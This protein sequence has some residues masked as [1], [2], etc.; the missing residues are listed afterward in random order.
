MANVTTHKRI[1]Y[2]NLH[3][4]DNT[5]KIIDQDEAKQLYFALYEW[6]S[7]ETGSKDLISQVL[8]S[9]KCN[10]KNG[11]LQPAA[12][13]YTKN[14]SSIIDKFKSDVQLAKSDLLPQGF[15]EI[16]RETHN[17]RES[18][19][20]ITYVYAKHEKD[21]TYGFRVVN[22]E[23]YPFSKLGRVQDPTCPM[24][25]FLRAIPKDQ[26]LVKNDFLKLEINGASVQ[27][28]LGG[29]RLKAIT[30]ILR[31]EDYIR[32]TPNR[33]AERHGAFGYFLNSIKCD[34]LEVETNGISI[35]SS[36]STGVSVET[37]S[38]RKVSIEAL[39]PEKV[40]V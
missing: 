8:L 10:S 22:G 20:P 25:K 19:T 6:L 21:G 28:R 31:I 30:D 35:E 16:G 7:S 24:G 2:C 27:N 34:E 15:K 3:F 9:D 26:I 23:Q 29:R 40:G 13:T 38:K 39:T 36:N 14:Y 1:S 17:L 32:R 18:N 33:L 12:E 11:S 4:N 37:N 5:H